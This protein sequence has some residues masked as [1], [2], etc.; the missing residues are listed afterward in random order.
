MRHPLSDQTVEG[1]PTNIIKSRK[2]NYCTHISKMHALGEFSLFIS[3]LVCLLSC[4]CKNVQAF[5]M[6]LFRV[7]LISGAFHLF[8]FPPSVRQHISFFTSSVCQST[9][10]LIKCQIHSS[11]N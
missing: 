6:I 1:S 2:S 11:C 8:S 10:L 7:L 9:G 4:L 5:P 3:L